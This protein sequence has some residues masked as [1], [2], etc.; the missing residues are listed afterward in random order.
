[1]KLQI[2]VAD[3]QGTVMDTGWVAV[4]RSFPD[5][6]GTRSGPEFFDAAVLEGAWR[7][8][9]GLGFPASADEAEDDEEARP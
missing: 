2:V 8:K 3:E 9:L 1:M 7:V 6:P 5:R 4:P